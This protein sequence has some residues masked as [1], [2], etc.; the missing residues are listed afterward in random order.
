MTTKGERKITLFLSKQQYDVKM[1]TWHNWNSAFS[2]LLDLSGQNWVSPSFRTGQKRARVWNY[3]SIHTIK[4]K[5]SKASG[6]TLHFSSLSKWYTVW[7]VNILGLKEG[8][9]K[10][11]IPRYQGPNSM[12]SSQ[13]HMRCQAVNSSPGRVPGNSSSSAPTPLASRTHI[14]DRKRGFRFVLTLTKLSGNKP[15]L[16]LICPSHQ[17]PSSFLML[18]MISP[19]VIVS[20][21]SCWAW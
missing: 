8:E 13:Q 1:E 6:Q 21:S 3:Q 10:T 20:S 5:T 2:L 7:K 14:G 15:L 17:P 12:C 11:C 19:T 9:F 18:V 4:S 16:P